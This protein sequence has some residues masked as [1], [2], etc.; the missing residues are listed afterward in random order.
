MWWRNLYVWCRNPQRA[1]AWCRWW[2]RPLG[3]MSLQ[4]KK[5]VTAKTTTQTIKQEETISLCT[6]NLP[7][8]K[9]YIAVLHVSNKK[10]AH[11]QRSVCKSKLHSPNPSNYTAPYS[12]SLYVWTSLSLNCLLNADGE[13]PNR[14]SSIESQI[15]G[16]RKCFRGLF[17]LQPDIVCKL[18][19][20][21]L[22]WHLKGLQTACCV[23][24]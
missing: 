17:P 14:E 21:L 1:P 24:H 10:I 15:F 6:Q 9:L 12:Q 11:K 8:S 5:Y 22:I 2:R 19:G 13:M 3:T 7:E 4:N 18:P 23:F 20:M 16:P